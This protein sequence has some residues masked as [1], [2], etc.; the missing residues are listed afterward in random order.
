[1]RTSLFGPFT[2]G[3]VTTC[4]HVEVN[5][6]RFVSKRM[7]F[8]KKVND[9]FSAYTIGE[10]FTNP[11]ENLLLC[12]CVLIMWMANLYFTLW[13][14]LI[15]LGQRCWMSH[16]V[17]SQICIFLFSFATE[18]A[19]TIPRKTHQ[20]LN[21]KAIV[22]NIGAGHCVTHVP[23]WLLKSTAYLFL[24]EM[25]IIKMT[26]KLNEFIGLRNFTI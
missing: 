22:F 10:S 19:I 8:G 24:K 3:S 13:M 9:N 6:E 1:M 17:T 23:L 14:R 2:H 25:V 12:I 18:Q 11:G 20:T 4:N 7:V 16:Y 15:L 21:F 5:E 26:E